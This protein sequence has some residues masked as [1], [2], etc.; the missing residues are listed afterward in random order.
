[1]DHYWIIIVFGL[2]YASLTINTVPDYDELAYVKYVSIIQEYMNSFT[3]YGTDSNIYKLPIAQTNTLN[4]CFSCTYTYITSKLCYTISKFFLSSFY[5]LCLKKF[6]DN[7]FISIFFILIGSNFYFTHLLGTYISEFSVGLILVC[8]TILTFF[9]KKSNY[10]RLLIIS[11]ILLLLSRTINLVFV[12]GTLGIVVFIYI[13]DKNKMRLIQIFKSYL[14][15]VIMLSPILYITIKSQIIY[16]ITNAT[17]L[18]FAQNWRDMVG[19]NSALELP[20]Y[21]LNT[22]TY[23]NPY[24]L[25]VLFLTSLFLFLF[26]NQ[27]NKL[28]EY[29]SIFLMICMVVF[30]FSSSSSN[31]LI[32]FWFIHYVF[33]YLHILYLQF[34]LN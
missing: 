25:Q 7:Y 14:Y 12:L 31:V 19:I 18:G 28:K 24:L 27:I 20:L 5:L 15:A 30:A 23:Y 11:I 1:M 26:K 32:I 33:Y 21:I 6:F 17:E 3:Q 16:Y 34:Y 2:S 29:S 8:I 22:S 4:N 13:L 10:N 9:D